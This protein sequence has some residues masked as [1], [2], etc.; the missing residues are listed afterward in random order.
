MFDD[1]IVVL[2]L[3]IVFVLNNLGKLCEFI[4]LF[5]MVGIEIVLQGDFVVFEVE[6]LFGM[7][8]ENVLIKV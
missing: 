1:C 5:L 4:V 3:C 6:E 8:I 2:L 7:F